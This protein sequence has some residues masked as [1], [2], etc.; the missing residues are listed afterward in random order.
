MKGMFDCENRDLYPKPASGKWDDDAVETMNANNCRANRLWCR[1]TK[2]NCKGL[3]EAKKNKDPNLNTGTC[4]A[5]PA[6]GKKPYFGCK[7]SKTEKSCG[8]MGSKCKW[9]ACD[10][11][12]GCYPNV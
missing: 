8:W 12:C 5:A 7:G 1:M 4:V 10:A 9:E 3:T 2:R 11:K 6:A